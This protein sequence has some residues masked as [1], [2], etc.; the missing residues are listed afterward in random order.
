[1]R[2]GQAQ[3]FPGPVN[4][5]WNSCSILVEL[6]WTRKPPREN[7]LAELSPRL[8]HQKYMNIS[9][10]NASGLAG[11][12]SGNRIAVER[13]QESR[14]YVRITPDQAEVSRRGSEHAI[15]S[16]QSQAA[17]DWTRGIK[18]TSA[19]AGA[20]LEHEIGYRSS[21]DRQPH[22]GVLR[23]RTLQSKNR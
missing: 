15:R 5:Q 2:R 6:Q 10:I 17:R 8:P 12:R 7:R 3:R 11:E 20:R 16:G 19:I 1:M 23:V 13:W 14:F 4:Y 18:R 21:A 22:S 9:R